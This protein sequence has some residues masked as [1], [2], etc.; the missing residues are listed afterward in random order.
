LF[1]RSCIFARSARAPSI[2]MPCF[3]ASFFTNMR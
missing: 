1:L 2:T 3:A